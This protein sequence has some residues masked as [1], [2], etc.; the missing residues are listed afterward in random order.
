VPDDA[1]LERTVAFD[2][3]TLSAREAR[4]FVRGVLVEAGHEHWV[5]A[6]ELAVS[7][8]VTNVVLHAHT[9]FELTVRL[10]DDHV[11]VEVRDWNP[12]LPQPRT[13]DDEATTGRGMALVETVTAASGVQSLGGEGK[14]VW[15]CVADPDA[16]ADPDEL[17]AAWDDSGWDVEPSP[18]PPREDLVAVRLPRMPPTLWLAARQHQDGL[19]RE[20]ALH[21]VA[22][23]DCG[24]TEE[25]LA[26]ADAA[27]ALLGAAVDAAVARARL[28]THE[29]LPLPENHPAPLPA[30]PA[31]LDLEVGV[32]AG[33]GR[34]FAV[35]HR[36]LARA[37]ELAH[38][39]ALLVAPGLPEVVAVTAWASD[40]VVRQLD[41]GEAVAWTG[42][43]DER[44][45][46]MGDDAGTP[47]PTGWDVASVRDAD[48]GAVAADD[49]N[50][51]VAISRPLAGLLGYEVDD[52]VGRRVVTIVPPR[53]REAHVAG[54]SRHLTTGEAH[55]LGVELDLPV[56]RRD[57]GEVQCR[58]VIE[59]QGTAD[60]RRVCTAWISP[61]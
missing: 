4:R 44:F 2:P 52:L 11:R 29:R 6:A 53:F 16:E 10:S 32:P 39:D 25:D 33:A 13:Y 14:V 46:R 51:I 41:G 55:V 27:R 20:L 59:Q 36:V 21:R 23:A 34:S 7:E 50:R 12:A 48:V 31:Q 26:Q 43:D 56:L 61:L 5:D 19:L 38:T 30:V 60:G 47:L 15:F 58:F 3:A 49:A 28:G 35:L 8:V 42:A 18:P 57:G 1:V 9:R 22:H 37:E 54:F 45:T 24:V 40:Q 17:L